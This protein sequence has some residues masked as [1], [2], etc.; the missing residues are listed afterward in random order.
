MPQMP[1]AATC[2]RGDFLTM[3]IGDTPLV[4]V[5]TA[6]FNAIEGLRETVASVSH[7]T[8]RSVEH[9]IVDGGSNDGTREFLESLGDAVRWISEPDEGIADAMNKGIAMARGDYVLVL[10]AEDR[11][12]DQDSLLRARRELEDGADL[13]NFGVIL[14]KQEGVQIILKPRPF[15]FF[16]NL[17]MLNPHQGLFTHKTVFE[18]IGPFDA[19]FR[20]G[21]DYEHLLR[22]KKA[23]FNLRAVDDVLAVMPATGVSSRE[24]WAAKHDLMMEQ[25]RA[26][27]KTRPGAVIRL[28]YAL[29]WIGFYPAFF[30]KHRFFRNRRFY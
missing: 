28:G 26:Q 8:F 7:Q 30:V 18:T 12:V 9:I 22:A 27:V 6:T 10:H 14:A 29:F 4:S 21:M 5:V 23:G 24:N 1:Q 2:R 17:R 11:F 20:L 19:R 16:T 13:V 3:D 25:W 15:S